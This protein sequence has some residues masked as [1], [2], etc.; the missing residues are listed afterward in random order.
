MKYIKK[1][2]YTIE[3]EAPEKVIPSEKKEYSLN[4]LKAQER[5]ILAQIERHTARFQSD[6]DEVREMIEKATELGIKDEDKELK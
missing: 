6:L 1:D 2:E 4:Y 3:V 5:A